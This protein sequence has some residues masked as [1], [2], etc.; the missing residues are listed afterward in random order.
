MLVVPPRLIADE[1]E[2][3]DGLASD[4]PAALV[5]PIAVRARDGARLAGRWFPIPGQDEVGRTVILLHGFAE[6]SSALESRRVATFHRHGWNVASLDSRGYGL[7]EGPF[8]SFGGREADDIR[9]W[10]DMLAEHLRGSTR[11]VRFRP[12]LWGRSMGAA[13]ALRAAA[14]DSRIV[15]LVLESPMVDLDASVAVLLR[16][17]WLP[18]PEL[19][20]R[21]VTRRAGKLAGV[22]LSRPRPIDSA[23]CVT[24][25]TL[26][27]HGTDDWLVPIAE[28]RRLADAFPTP[29][30]WFDVAGAGHTNVIAKGAEPLFEQIAAFLDEVTPRADRAG[31]ESPGEM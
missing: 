11:P 31:A 2:Q 29:P 20:A 16:K 4:E 23:P 17:K 10:L 8:A 24:C 1:N 5:E 3:T 28:A 15:A 19:L 14:A 6:R 22:S 30:R 25:P 26:I 18:F 13:I 27:V 21:L 9:A 12:T 7:S